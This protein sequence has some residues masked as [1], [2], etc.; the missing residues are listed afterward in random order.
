[1]SRP[2]EPQ[3]DSVALVPA[4][5]DVLQQRCGRPVE[6]IETHISWVLLDGEHAWKLKKPLV[7][8]FL[9][10]R[11]LAVRRHYCEEELRLNQ[12]LAPS[13]YLE[14]VPVRGSPTAP[15]LGDDDEAGTVIE[16]ALRMKQFPAGA[17]FA[18]RIAA[19]Q[20]E[21]TAVDRFAARLAAFQADALAAAPAT[22]WGSPT[23]IRADTRQVLASLV[24]QGREPERIAALQGWCEARGEHLQADFEQRQMR[25]QVREG[26]GDLHLANIVILQDE[27]TAFDCIEFDPGLRWIDVQNDIAFLTMDF[28]AH[29]HAELKWR[30]LDRWLMTTGD[31]AGLRVLRYYEVYRALVRAL[32]AGIRRA[33]LGTTAG[34]DYLAS[35]EELA[36]EPAASLLVTCGLSGSG[37]SF[38]SERLL[39]AAGAIRLRSDVERKRLSGFAA[40]APSGSELG[41][42]LYTDEA[43]RRTYV[44]LRELAA[45]LLLAGYRVIVDA[46][47]LL[48]RERDDFRALADELRVPFAIL[49]CDAPPEELRARIR[50]RAASRTDASE[51]DCAVLE[52]QIAYQE[53][54]RSAEHTV[55]ISLDTTG[56]I[57]VPALAARWLQMHNA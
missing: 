1:M 30:F 13:I 11:E 26:H 51:A 17:L 45:E 41:K 3:A 56:T 33:Q 9:D 22:S 32:V 39:E 42:Q 52:H 53:P 40:D 50:A 31:Y 57:D 44:R 19:G 43:T 46:T 18:E 25:G 5:R 6:C 23:R 20:L 35:A 10:F 8:G 27:V 12:R 38:V 47:F 28:V 21:A 54:L 15:T 2:T 37:K 24:E 34:P 4:L 14:V 55:T 7:L 48:A 49:H 16:Y 36:R 29:G